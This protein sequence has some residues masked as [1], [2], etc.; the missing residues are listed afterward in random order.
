MTINRQSLSNPSGCPNIGGHFK[1]SADHGREKSCFC[2]ALTDRKLAAPGLNSNL[3]FF[4]G[5]PL[6]NRED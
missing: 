6:S 3:S 5:L 2:S 4:F 1:Y